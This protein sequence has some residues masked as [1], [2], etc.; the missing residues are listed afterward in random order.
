[1]INLLSARVYGLILGKG[2]EGGKGI[3]LSV[4]GGPE[5]PG[6]MLLAYLS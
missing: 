2:R 3:F 1:M 4:N 5:Q 6:K